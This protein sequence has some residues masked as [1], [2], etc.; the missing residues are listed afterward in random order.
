MLVRIVSTRCTSDRHSKQYH[1]KQCHSKASFPRSGRSVNSVGR[2][3]MVS[4]AGLRSAGKRPLQSRP[5]SMILAASSSWFENSASCPPGIATM[6]AKPSRA[7]NRECH[8][9]SPWG[10]AMSSVQ[11]M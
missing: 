1:S 9:N 10:M 2:C 5:A 3:L 7:L 11:L 6:R 4:S 8:A